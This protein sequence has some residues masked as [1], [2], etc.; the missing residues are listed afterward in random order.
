MHKNHYYNQAVPY[1]HVLPRVK[2]CDACYL[3]VLSC[4]HTVID[5][6]VSAPP[7]Q[8]HQHEHGGTAHL[9][10][11]VRDGLKYPLVTSTGCIAQR[12]TIDKWLLMLFV[13]IAPLLA[14][15]V[16]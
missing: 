8:V 5:S 12:V 13:F 15:V 1:A 16:Q 7:G 10:L 14:V 9:K 4:C 11:R 3:N 2:A 6:P